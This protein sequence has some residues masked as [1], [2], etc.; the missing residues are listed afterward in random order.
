MKEKLLVFIPM[1]FL[2]MGRTLTFSVLF[3]FFKEFGFVLVICF[4]IMQLLILSWYCN[5][6]GQQAILGGVISLFS[7]SMIVNDFTYYFLVNGLFSTF[8]CI[9]ILCII[10]YFVKFDMKPMSGLIVKSKTF[11]VIFEGR[12]NMLYNNRNLS[13]YPL[14]ELLVNHS[15]YGFIIGLF[16]IL[17]FS[18]ACVVYLHFYIDPIQRLRLS[19][20]VSKCLVLPL[21]FLLV[22]TLCTIDVIMVALIILVTPLTICF[23]SK[24]CQLLFCNTYHPLSYDF[25]TKI[26]DII[27]FIHIHP[28]H[29]SLQQ[30]RWLL[31][32]KPEEKLWLQNIEDYL[33]NKESL[34]NLC[35]YVKDEF[36]RFAIRTKKIKLVKVFIF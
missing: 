12:N 26:V 8:G 2:T 29:W 3:A 4:L 9:V 14:I 27:K 36:L 11:P 30:N 35:E 20:I 25:I 16:I 34:V 22:I 13:A 23:L 17:L 5:Q 6:Y 28:M 31:V 15:L 24:P 32:W 33:E 7:P 21:M 1:L 10:G 19:K 18:I